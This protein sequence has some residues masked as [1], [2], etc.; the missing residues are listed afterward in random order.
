MV[1]KTFRGV[2]VRHLVIWHCALGR[3]ND[4]IAGRV[5]SRLEYRVGCRVH[6]LPTVDAQPPRTKSKEIDRVGLPTPCPD[7]LHSGIK[8]AHMSVDERVRTAMAH[9]IVA[10]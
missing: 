9:E 2:F 1:S 6:R 4:S 8:G 7:P 5:E 3:D 10:R